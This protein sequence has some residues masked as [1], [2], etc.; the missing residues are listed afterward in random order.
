MSG[1]LNFFTENFWATATALGA[2]A[3]MIAG[4]INGKFNPSAIWRQIIAWAISIALTVGGYFL[5]LVSVADPV[6]LT[7]TATGLIVGLVSNG[8]YDIPVIK[9]FI[10]R[11]FGETTTPTN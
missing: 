9:E 3:S 7:L 5:G 2:V 10:R 1:V 8:I 4:A 11:I 6:W